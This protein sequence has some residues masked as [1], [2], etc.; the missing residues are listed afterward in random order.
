MRTFSQ[1]SYDDILITLSFCFAMRFLEGVG[2]DAG[3]LLGTAKNWR[4]GTMVPL[5][6]LDQESTVSLI[7]QKANKYINN[8][9]RL[10]PS[11]GVV[12]GSMVRAG[13]RSVVVSSG[14]K[15]LSC[16]IYGSMHVGSSKSMPSPAYSMQ[17]ASSLINYVKPKY[18]FTDITTWHKWN[19]S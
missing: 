9:T 3:G 13:P 8:S 11:T 4:W 6:I 7:H 10:L 5:L 14:A 18:H 19:T 2:G 17:C 16:S 15:H 12:D 1:V